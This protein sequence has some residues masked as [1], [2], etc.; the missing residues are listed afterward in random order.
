MYPES[1]ARFAAITMFLGFLTT[2]L[3]Q[4]V[5]GYAGMPRRYQIY[6]PEFQIYHV[7]SSVGALILAVAYVLPLIYLGWSLLHG[8]RA[9][10][11]P[12][13]ATGL[14]W[15]TSSPPPKENFHGTPRVEQAP[16][17]YHEETTGPEIDRRLPAQARGE[18]P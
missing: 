4:Y 12:W 7:M 6:P 14:E 18:R 5:M 1:W 13:G 15:Q 9:D 16:Y 11:N 3:P 2:F 8:Q 10:D 17:L